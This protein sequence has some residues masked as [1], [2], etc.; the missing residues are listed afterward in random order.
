MKELELKLIS[1]LMKNSHRSD[2]ELSKTLHVSQPTVTRI[3][4]RL[5]EQGY[6]R[7]YTAIPDFGK[8]GFQIMSFTLI[9]LKK[10]DPEVE[11]KIRQQLRETLK[12]KPFATIIVL[13]GLG[14]RSDRISVAFHQNYSEYLDYIAMMKQHP[15][16]NIEETTSF[17]ANLAESHHFQLLT[18]SQIADYVAKMRTE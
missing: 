6:I 14:A 4:R 5:E 12:K 3:R 17:L 18:F 10:D 8:L 15:L 13:N 11:T 9:K 16:V 7:E 2:R 1:A